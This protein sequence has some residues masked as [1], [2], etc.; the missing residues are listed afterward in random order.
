[1]NGY[2]PKRD[3]IFFNPGQPGIVFSHPAEHFITIP[4]L[5]GAQEYFAQTTQKSIVYIEDR[6]LKVR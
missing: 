2:L 5:I 4:E 1:M 3:L 6:R